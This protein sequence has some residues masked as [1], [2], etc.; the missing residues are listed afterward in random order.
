MRTISPALANHIAQR[1]TT[2][3]RLLH[4]RRPDGTELYFCDNSNSVE[5][6]GEDY[7]ADISFTSSAIFTTS[8]IL[9]AQNV[10]LNAVMSD[11][12]F[13]EADMR[14]RRYVGA[15]ASIMLVNYLSPGDGALILFHGIFGRIE[16]SD[17]RRC[18]FE[19]R[20]LSSG[21]GNQIT[22]EVYSATCRN[23]L[24]DGLPPISKPGGCL[25]DIEHNKG[26]FTVDVNS[27]TKNSFLASELSQ[28]TNHWKLGHVKWITGQNA[29]LL[30]EVQSS[31]DTGFIELVSSLLFPIQA[32]DQG[33]IFQGCDK[34]LTTCHD[35]FEQVAN[36]R[37]E[38]YVPQNAIYNPPRTGSV[39]RG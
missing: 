16:I 6:E 25:Y 21:A 24:G 17:K 29:G 33:D 35:T 20:P 13:K 23:A 38:P 14:A 36:F 22:N 39:L 27:P 31:D 34:Q 11:D 10:D 30:S 7:R 9:Q 3:C 8:T 4:V 32:L 26:S 2:L 15:T 37:G 12:G 28:Y 19:L 18:K 1:T 5:F